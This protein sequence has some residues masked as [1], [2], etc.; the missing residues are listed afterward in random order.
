MHACGHDGHMAMLLG[1]AEVLTALRAD[2]AGEI[3]FIFQPAE[4]FHPGGAREVA[5]GGFLR[6]LDYVVGTHLWSTVPVGTINL[7]PG[8][9][10]AAPDNFTITIR[11]RGG[12]A[13]MPQTTV[14]P[15]VIAAHV[16]LALQSL[17]TRQIDPL[18]SAVISVT[19]I[20]GGTAFNIIPDE[21]TLK[22]TVRVFDEELR[23]LL[24]AK[25]ERTARGVGQTFGAECTFLLTPGYDVV[26][27][28]PALT[29]RLERAFR[30]Y[31]PDI[32]LAAGEPMMCGEDFSAYQ[33]YAPG[34]YFFTGAGNAALDAVYPQHHCRYRIDEESLKTG[35]RALVWGALALLDAVEV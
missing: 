14:D 33:K 29:A 28:D 15:V 30:R 22:G 21:V 16:V 19:A 6:D 1:A 35:L 17:L 5:A 26:D 12:H 34:V 23:A 32:A 18:Q 10:M 27:N 11:G 2:W 7:R 9:V 20:N 8:P 13:A 31:L 24:P 3:R 4:E 25:M